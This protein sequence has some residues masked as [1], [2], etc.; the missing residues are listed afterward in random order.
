MKKFELFIIIYEFLKSYKEKNEVSES[1]NHF[2]YD[3]NPYVWKGCISAD[4]ALYKEFEHYLGKSTIS[5]DNSFDIV[6]EYMYSLKDEYYDL[7]EMKKAFDSI[8]KDEW[9]NWCADLMS[10]PLKKDVY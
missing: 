2:L 9:I 7:V 10:K 4:P 5:L 8:S 3:S 1:F 6:K